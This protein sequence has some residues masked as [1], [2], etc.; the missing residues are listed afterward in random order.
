MIIIGRLVFLAGHGKAT[1]LFLLDTLTYSRRQTTGHH[2]LQAMVS[3][4]ILTSTP[5]NMAN[6]IS[7]L[8]WPKSRMDE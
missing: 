1:P 2:L 3:S 5:K 8:L 7:S 6:T 4:F